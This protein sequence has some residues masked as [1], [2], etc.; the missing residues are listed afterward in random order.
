MFQDPYSILGVKQGCSEDELKSAYRKLAKQYH[1]D[2]H[3][4]DEEAARKMNEINAAYEQIKNP[5]KT[6]YQAY[7]GAQSPY[8]SAGQTGPFTYTYYSTGTN[9]QDG[10]DPFADIF[11]GFQEQSY[12]SYRRTVRPGR[13]ILIM[14]VVFF[15]FRL[16]GTFLFSGLYGNYGRSGSPYYYYYYSTPYSQSEGSSSQQQSGQNNANPYYS[17]F[18]G[19]SDSTNG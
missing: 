19:N 4:G 9:G 12:T 3:P 18:F 17:F 16:L 6:G 13:I 11:R 2:L 7:G 8:G 14:M 5:P 1:P 15:I 10:Y